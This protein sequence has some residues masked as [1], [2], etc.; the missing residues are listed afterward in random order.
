MSR[1]QRS[2][3]VANRLETGIAVS[4]AG[5]IHGR[6]IAEALVAFCRETGAAP[7]PDPEA[8]I[9]ACSAMLDHAGML[10]EGA[11]DRLTK[12]LADDV[13]ARGERDAAAADLLGVIIEIRG[14]LELYGG[15][16]PSATYGLSG[17]TPRGP[18]ELLG[19]ARNVAQLLRA[20]DRPIH[21]T[22][23]GGTTTA[24]LAARLDAPMARLQAA[25]LAMQ[26]EDREAEQALLERDR[27]LARWE[28][29][30][31]G[32]AGALEGLMR[33]AGRRDMA[34]RL[35]PTQRK[36]LGQEVQPPEEVATAEAPAQPATPAVPEPV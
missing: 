14:L 25:N 6:V 33:L 24:V 18:K 2:Q 36:L 29:T 4:A 35:R 7:P 22:G 26:D 27:A 23:I 1:T 17:T 5:R 19:W 20:T 9:L 32:A 13:S 21:V 28:A 8:F 30:Y 3:Q 12:E 11:E 31:Q 15:H 16:Q 10:L 34:D